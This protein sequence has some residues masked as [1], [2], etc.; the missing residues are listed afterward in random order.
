LLLALA[1]VLGGA[2]SANPPAGDASDPD[3]GK[4]LYNLN[5]VAMPQGDPV[6]DDS[7]CTNRIFFERVSSVPLG[8]ISWQL[9]PAA[10]GLQITD[11]DGTADKEADIL[12]D[13]EVE[14][15]VMIRVAGA[16]TDSLDLTCL[17]ILEQDVD[18]LCLNNGVK[19]TYHNDKAFTKVMFNVSDNAEEEV[20][21]G[22]TTSTGFRM[23]QVRI[24]EKL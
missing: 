15:W 2:A 9:D 12:V 18:D 10:N 17:E 22:L 6:S 8:D 19:V 13:E 16:K 11:C 20:E 4:L 23:A 3:V 5:I 7:T 21:W 24:Y 14:F 1:A